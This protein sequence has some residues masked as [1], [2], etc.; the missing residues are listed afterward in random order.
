M[1]SAFFQPRATPIEKV[2][3]G[4]DSL[5]AS[6]QDIDAGAANWVRDTRERQ[7]G[8][9]AIVV[10]GET[11]RG[12]SSLVNAMLASPG[13][14]PVDAEVATAT[15]LRFVSGDEP[16]AQACY[17]GQRPP[18]PFELAEL[19]N[20]T[21]ATSE[22]P[23]GQLPPSYVEVAYPCPLLARVS[24]V[25]TPGVGGLDSMHGELA[26]EA[27]ASATALLFVVDASS[28]FTASELNFLRKMSDRV[29][30][31]LFALSKTDAF[32]GWRQVAA[33]NT[34]LLA[35][36]APRF[37]DAEFLPV[38][39]R[40]FELAGNAPSDDAAAMLRQKSGVIALQTAVQEAVIGKADALREANTLRTLVT[41][42][43]EQAARLTA[44]RRA[45]NS[46]ES[47]G[48]A[49][50]E[51]RDALRAERKSSTRGWQLTLRSEIQRARTDCT[52]EVARQ[53]RDVQSWFR[54]RIDGADADV[55]NALP[56]EV[57]S[58]LQLVSSRLNTLLDQRLNAATNNALAELFSEDE[59]RVIRAQFARGD[60]RPVVL[61][62]PDKR[63]ATAEDKL[64][65]G[66][67]TYMGIGASGTG[68]SLATGGA[69]TLATAGL[70]A[71]PVLAVGLGAGWWIGRTR[72]HAAN[73][74]HVKTWLTEAIA[75]ARSAVDQL[76][77]EQIID[78][79]H[80]LSL[81]LDEALTRRI[82][83]I[84]AEIK[85][86]DKTLKLSAAEK[87]KQLAAVS[88]HLTEAENGRETAQT[89]LGSL[90]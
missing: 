3:K 18:V 32:K 51:R 54:Q 42:F 13:L 46:G 45:L 19:A 7:Q 26:I 53:M 72:R 36:H 71:V 31:V 60:S 62:P 21:S 29:E 75:D 47:E 56:Q 69:M 63:P 6:L 52:H 74:Q 27:A 85:E 78:A 35:T 1:T 11:K 76:V 4:C 79:E 59:L 68:L 15:Y 90:R 39:A 87:S 73:K 38:S 9:P 64:M 40:M 43:E 24:L 33:A 66:M 17:P 14:S 22:L 50:R 23:E 12:K 82:E 84:E 5:I 30:T 61:R 81:A 41:A 57:D 58:A 89:L 25:D 48:D 70:V 44:E 10:V 86:V 65:V 49:L 37:A 28:P 67:G 8:A 34:E 16:R 20:W 80:Q 55:L 77:S 83:A 2:R 88:A